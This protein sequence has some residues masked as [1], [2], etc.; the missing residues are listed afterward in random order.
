MVFAGQPEDGDVL[1]AGGGGGVLGFADGG[2]GFE[3]GEERAAEEGD[4]LAG[5]DGG[6]A[7][8]E[9]FDVRED[10]PGGI[11]AVGLAKERVAQGEAVGFREGGG[12]LGPGEGKGVGGI[13]AAEGG[14]VGRGRG[15]RVVAEERCDAGQRRDGEAVRVHKVSVSHLRRFGC[16]GGGRRCRRREGRGERGE[17][18]E[19]KAQ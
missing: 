8:A 13:P 16:G 1:A 7:V 15:F 14:G 5:D 18:R 11:E 2:G 17:R 6:G 3:Q 4:L 19:N 10:G 12:R 9:A